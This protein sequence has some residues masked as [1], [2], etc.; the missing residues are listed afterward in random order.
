[1]KAG[2]GGQELE[3]VPHPFRLHESHGAGGPWESGVQ[4]PVLD[5]QARP[6]LEVKE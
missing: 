3:S 1:M 6:T 4:F 2:F 5:L